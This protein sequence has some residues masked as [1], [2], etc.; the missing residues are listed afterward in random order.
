LTNETKNGTIE[1]DANPSLWDHQKR[2]AQYAREPARALFWQPRV[3]KTRAILAQLDALPEATRILVVVPKT[4]AP[5]WM[6]EARAWGYHP[7]DLSSGSVA[8]RRIILSRPVTGL[9]SGYNFVI[10]NYDVLPMLVK[11]LVKWKPHV[12][13]ADEAHLIKNVNAKRSKALHRLGKVASYRRILTGTPD[14]Q[15]YVDF[16]SQ[17]KFL[18][19]TVFGTVKKAYTERYVK[20]HPLYKNKVLSYYN[21]S[22]LREKVFHSASRVRGSDVSDVP[23]VHEIIRHVEMPQ[24]QHTLYGRLVEDYISKDPEVDATHALTRLLRLQQLTSGVLPGAEHQAKLQAVIGE[25]GEPLSAGEKVVIFHRFR[26]EGRQLF[27]AIASAYGDET[28][29]A[30]NGDTAS[31]ERRILTKLFNAKDDKLQV[32]VVQE[33]VGSL[34]ISLAAANLAIFTSMGFDYATHVQARDRIWSPGLPLTYVYITVPGTV[35]T[36]IH[37]TVKRKESASK[38]ILDI[39]FEKA[40][41]GEID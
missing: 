4:V 40:Y 27:Q 26:E 18:D 37:N 13:V 24:M 36:F 17:Y 20:F 15:S 9:K 35:D 10:V 8:D 1:S 5:V 30:L 31:E 6:E 21:L 22:E 3:G 28:V 39:G 7:T 23:V 29:A 2:E 38:R 33:Q 41:R 12:V 34:G 32:L 19:P 14:P 25:I 16:Y 11:D